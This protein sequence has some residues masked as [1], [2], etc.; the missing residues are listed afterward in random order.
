M[1]NIYT[2]L[3]SLLFLACGNKENKTE[4]VENTP[5][6]SNEISVTK[7]Q[8]ESEQM[9]LDT[10]KTLDFSTGIAVTGMIDVPPKNSYK[11]LVL[12]VLVLYLL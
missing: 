2:L 8:F 4:T 5:T 1:K 3:F 6:K 10:L 7:A 11:L 12:C 9:V